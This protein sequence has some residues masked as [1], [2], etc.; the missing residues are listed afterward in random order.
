MSRI[1]RVFWRGGPGDT[2]I[3]DAVALRRGTVFRKVGQS[4][5]ISHRIGPHRVGLGAPIGRGDKSYVAADMDLYP[6]VYI[7][8]AEQEAALIA[9]DETRTQRLA[10]AAQEEERWASFDRDWES[11]DL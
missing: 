6:E 7:I 3:T 8:T 1:V 11:G 5:S 9:A 10:V 4:T 2:C